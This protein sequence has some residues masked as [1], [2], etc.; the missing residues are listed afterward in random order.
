MTTFGVMIDRIEDEID[1]QT[2][3]THVRRAIV[4]AIDHLK[5]F[6]FPWNEDTFSF[7]TVD[8]EDTYLEVDTPTGFTGFTL[9]TTSE[10]LELDRILEIDYLHYQDG[11]YRYEL[12]RENWNQ[13]KDITIDG[14]PDGVPDAYAMSGHGILLYPEPNDAYTIEG[15]CHFQLERLYIDSDTAITNAWF[16]RA[17]ELV[18]ARALMYLYGYT[19]R[20]WEHAKAYKELADIELQKHFTL[21]TKLVSSRNVEAYW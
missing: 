14:S 16:T 15:R 7:E 21:Y 2:E 18:R 11:G 1:R 10:L 19:F 5:V 12:R 4:S 3:E 13:L 8:G 17:E 20:D 9:D 6:R